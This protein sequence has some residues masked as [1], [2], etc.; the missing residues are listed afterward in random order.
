MQLRTAGIPAQQIDSKQFVRE[1]AALRIRSPCPRPVLRCTYGL[2]PPFSG[3]RQAGSRRRLNLDFHVS[4]AARPVMALPPAA[5]PRTAVRWT[6]SI[7]RSQ[8]G[9]K[10][11][12][13]GESM[14]AAHAAR[15]HPLAAVAAMNLARS[16]H[17]STCRRDW[18]IPATG[19]NTESKLFG[20]A[21]I[22]RTESRR[23][24]RRRRPGGGPPSAV[25][26]RAAASTALPTDARQ[27]YPGS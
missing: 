11:P 23:G 1:S 24:R 14:P 20:A 6:H 5:T 26:R 4:C 22:T 15:R 17:L 8:S 7:N 9:K 13:Q 10:M 12:S 25:T 2:P 16:R 27:P 3:L 19:S 18:H 21:A